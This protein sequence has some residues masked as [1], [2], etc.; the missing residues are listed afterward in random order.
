MAHLKL[1]LIKVTHYRVVP[2]AVRP[3]H[4]S[5]ASTTGCPRARLRNL[6]LLVRFRAGQLVTSWK[7]ARSSGR[8]ASYTVHRFPPL[9]NRES[10]GHTSTDIGYGASRGEIAAGQSLRIQGESHLRQRQSDDRSRSSNFQRAQ[11][12]RLASIPYRHQVPRCNDARAL[13]GRDIDSVRLTEKRP[14]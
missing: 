5:G 11:E 12:L 3:A 9:A 8:A 7:L 4:L 1:R 14:R 13:C 10:P 6:A 2:R